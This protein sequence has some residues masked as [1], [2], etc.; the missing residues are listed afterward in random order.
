MNK[1]LLIFFFISIGI[2][3]LGAVEW[4][5]GKYKKSAGCSADKA[6]NNKLPFYT[7]EQ[8][9]SIYQGCLAK[10]DAKIRWSFPITIVG[11]ISTVIAVVIFFVT[12]QNLRT[13]LE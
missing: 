4:G 9:E 1:L 11:I 2:L 6:I 3:I 5:D 12:G 8:T 7:A 10:A 13:I